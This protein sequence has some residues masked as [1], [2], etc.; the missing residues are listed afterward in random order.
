MNHYVY[1]IEQK[2]PLPGQ[3][4]QYIGVRSCECNVGDDEYMSSSK[5]VK[6]AIEKYG[7][8]QFNKIILK[9]FDNRRDANKYEMQLQE[10]FDVSKSNF[11]FN[12][13]KTKENGL[14]VGPGEMNPFYGKR[15][16]EEYKQMLREKMKTVDCVPKKTRKG[17]KH[18]PEAKA[19]IKA[20]I[21]KK[22]A[23]GTW[24]NNFNYDERSE[25]H[26][27]KLSESIRKNNKMATCIHCGLKTRPGN[28]VKWHNDKCK[29]KVL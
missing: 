4:V 29:K 2:N 1:L 25:L 20:V 19:K 12:R 10:E 16:T 14:G 11:F 15:H 18:T 21:A 28:I 5:Y 9:R 3:P 17:E 27:K 26:K 13:I 7:K 8:N 6:E 22:M 23:E 24:V